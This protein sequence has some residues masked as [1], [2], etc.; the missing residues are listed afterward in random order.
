MASSSTYAPLLVGKGTARDGKWDTMLSEDYRR[1]RFHISYA[2]AL[3]RRLRKNYCYI[4]TVQAVAYVGKHVAVG[5]L[6]VGDRFE[7]P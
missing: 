1:P 3:G 4:L 2:R 6:P 7:C 5:V